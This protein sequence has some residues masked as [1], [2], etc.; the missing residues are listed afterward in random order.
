[1]EGTGELVK[2]DA[3][4][5]GEETSGELDALVAQ[6][7]ELRGHDVRRRQTGQVAARPGAAYGETSARSAPR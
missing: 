2:I 1:M 4:A 5:P 6:R 3:H 7:V